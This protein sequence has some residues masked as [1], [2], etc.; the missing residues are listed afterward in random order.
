ML[1]F[2]CAFVPGLPSLPETM[3]TNTAFV[4]VPSMPSQ[5]AST[6]CMSG[7]SVMLVWLH[8][9]PLDICC[10]GTERS[11]F[12][13]KKPI[14]QVQLHVVP[15]Q[16]VVAFGRSGHGFWPFTHSFFCASHVHWP[17]HASMFRRSH[18]ESPGMHGSDCT[19]FS[20][21][22]QYE[23]AGHAVSFG[24]CTQRFF[25]A[26]H[27]SCVHATPSSQ[28]MGLPVSTQKPPLHSRPLFPWQRSG[29]EQSSFFT[30]GCPVLPLPASPVASVPAS[31]APKVPG[32]PL[33]HPTTKAREAAHTPGRTRRIAHLAS[34]E[35]AQ[36]L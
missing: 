28:L 6:N 30:H 33:A 29:R 9:H 19:Q 17:S 3:S 14:L 18:T 35:K 27:T 21:G 7:L 8:S 23:L 24:V 32:E 20:V 10:A 25:V 36:L 26:S 5:S 16:V 15:M 11:A 13:S 2:G 22:L 34:T 31:T 1:F 4:I 12:V